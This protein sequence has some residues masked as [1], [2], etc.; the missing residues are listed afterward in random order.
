MQM[1]HKLYDKD[2]G[3]DKYRYRGANLNTYHYHYKWVCMNLYNGRMTYIGLVPVSLLMKGQSLIQTV[4]ILQFKSCAFS[5][6][7][8]MKQLKPSITCSGPQFFAF[9]NQVNPFASVTSEWKQG[10]TCTIQQHQR[11]KIYQYFEIIIILTEIFFS[12]NYQ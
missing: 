12:S 10:Y 7:K 2:G 8:K 9:A 11:M 6:N 5:E 3:Y 4:N 1:Y